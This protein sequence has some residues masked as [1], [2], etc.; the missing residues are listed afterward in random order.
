MLS[1][2]VSLNALRAFELAARLRSMTL[3]ADEL[4][5]TS[6]AVSRYVRAL[7]ETLGVSLLQRGAHASDP[8]LE[9]QRLA[10]DLV[11]GPMHVQ[12]GHGRA[13][14][15]PSET[16]R[17]TVEHPVGVGPV[18]PHG[19]A[20]LRPG[21]PGAVGEG[22]C[23]TGRCRDLPAPAFAQALFARPSQRAPLRRFTACRGARCDACGKPGLERGGAMRPR[24]SR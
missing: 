22:A 20:H 11:A 17:G 23:L 2:R 16:D 9:G 14:T 18:G 13:R 8:T 7:E 4:C 19:L 5:V 24:S 12:F 21:G 6:S 3:A 15:W 10:E 1:R